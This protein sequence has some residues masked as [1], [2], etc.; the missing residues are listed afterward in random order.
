MYELAGAVGLDPAT[1][2][3]GASSLDY[4]RRHGE[5][6]GVVVELPYWTD[7]R[8]DDTSPDPQGRARRDVVLAELERQAESIGQ[9]RKLY[10]AAAPLPSSLIADAVTS[11]LALESGY[12][13]E[14]RHEAETDPDY[15]RTATVAE[16]FSLTD[17][18][19][20]YRLR[21]LGMLGRALPTGSPV[22][23]DVEQLLQ[24]WSAEAQAE[25]MAE[26][27]PIDDLVAVQ[28]GAILA[29]VAHANAE[30]T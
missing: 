26:T 30:R 28:A 1:F 8:A 25:S 2:V 29:A 9:I 12:G 27:I 22:A 4:A 11:F 6:V 16:V 7:P 10:D 23:P 5:P 15:A 20:S 21:L 3:S 14:R 18:P 13:D 17:E 19:T 24:Q